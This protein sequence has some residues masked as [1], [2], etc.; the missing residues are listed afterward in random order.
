M[1]RRQN[2]GEKGSVNRRHASGLLPQ[3]LDAGE[4]LPFDDEEARAARGLERGLCRTEN[5]RPRSRSS[6]GRPGRGSRFSPT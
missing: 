4:K 3:D 1:K 2:R 5:R 6:L